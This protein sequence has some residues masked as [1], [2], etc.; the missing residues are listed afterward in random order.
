MIDSEGAVCLVDELILPN[1]LLP[2]SLPPQAQID[3]Q[4]G[5]HSKLS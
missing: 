2:E 3:D 5:S 4:L 1:L